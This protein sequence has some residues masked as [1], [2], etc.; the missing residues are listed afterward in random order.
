MVATNEDG[1]AA[2]PEYDEAAIRFLAVLWGEGY[3]SPGGPAE[4][5]RVLA[6]VPLAGRKVLDFGCGAGGITLHIAKTHGPAE[7]VG[8]DVERPVIARARAS[9]MA[10]GLSSV[11]RFVSSPPGRLPFEDGA[12]DVIFSKDAM[13]HVPDKEALFAELYRVLRPGGIFA[14]SDW[15]IGHDGEPSA[16]MKDYIAAEGLHFGMA[17]SHRYLRAMAAAGFVDGTAESRNA[18][19]RD[20]AR[21]ELERLKGPLR[22]TA[23]AAV[24]EAYVEKNIRTWTAMQKVLDSGE[25]CPTHLRGSK[26]AAGVR[27]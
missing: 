21:G 10:A 9:A 14:A 22:A 3:L 18:W 11:A 8:Y 13:I 26:P 1:A 2:E 20:V 12:F 24:G 27:P 19:Y 7:V 17:S 23:V 6:G 16:D 15:L 5:D 25:H 4:V